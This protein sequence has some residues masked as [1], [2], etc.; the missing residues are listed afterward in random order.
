MYETKDGYLISKNSI[1]CGYRD[2]VPLVRE[3]LR[4]PDVPDR[5]AVESFGLIIGLLVLGVLGLV[6]KD[7]L[8]RG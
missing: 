1:V 7:R 4:T 8:K 2:G 6:V 3:A 5:V